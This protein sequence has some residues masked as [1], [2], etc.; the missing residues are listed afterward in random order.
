MTFQL[1]II[2]DEIIHGSRVD[3]HFSAIKTLLTEKPAILLY[4]LGTKSAPSGKVA[5]FRR[6]R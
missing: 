3:A 5:M 1:I 6:V 4:G 2:G